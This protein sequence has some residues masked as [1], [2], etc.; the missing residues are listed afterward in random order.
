MTSQAIASALRKNSKQHP[1]PNWYLEALDAGID[2]NEINGLEDSPYWEVVTPSAAEAIKEGAGVEAVGVVFVAIFGGT[3]IADYWH[4]RRRIL[5]N[6]EVPRSENA[7][8]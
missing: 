5:A 1:V 2:A 7:Q 6:N 4:G 8:E 3:L